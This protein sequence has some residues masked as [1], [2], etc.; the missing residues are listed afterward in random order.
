MTVTEQEQEQWEDIL[1]EVETTKGLSIE[2]N[3]DSFTLSFFLDEKNQTVKKEYT[4]LEFAAIA[5]RSFQDGE[6]AATRPKHIN[7]FQY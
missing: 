3:Q 5:I 4:N 1:L 2:I 7:R 6:R